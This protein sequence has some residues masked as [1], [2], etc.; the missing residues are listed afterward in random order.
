MKKNLHG[1]RFVGVAADGAVE[2]D[3]PLNRNR[4]AWWLTPPGVPAAGSRQLDICGLP[5]LAGSNHAIL[6]GTA[7]PTW[8]GTQN[9]IYS[10]LT[11][12]GANYSAV[13]NANLADNLGE[14]TVECWFQTSMTIGSGVSGVL[15]AKQTQTGTAAGWT[16]FLDGN[17]GTPGNVGIFISDT[18]WANFQ[19]WTTANAF[20][21]GK[22]HHAVCTL[23]GGAAGTITIYVDGVSQSLTSG[24]SGVL[25]NFSN[26]LTVTQG[27]DSGHSTSWSLTGQ[28][29]GA[30]VFSRALSAK[31]VLTAYSQGLQGYQT[32]DSPLRWISTRTWFVPVATGIAFD[33]ASNSGAL[34]TVVGTTITWNHTCTGTNRYLAVDVGILS[35]GASVVSVTYNGVNL[36]I[37]KAQTTVTALGDVECWGL[38]NPASGTNSIVVTI[39]GSGLVAG[40]QAVSYTNVDQTVPTEAAAGNQATNVGATDATVSVTTITDQ[41]WI[42]AA[43]IANDPTITAN[44]I[45]RSNVTDG[46][47]NSLADEDFGPQSPAAKTMGYTGVGAGVTWAIV[48]YGIRPASSFYLFAQS[49][50]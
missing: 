16:F 43:V 7:Q 3:H 15:V 25:A 22:W 29:A 47:T 39:S 9:N 8:S 20:N 10:P 46:L 24:G 23:T 35:A 34:A 19:L 26:A 18:G 30:S 4:L 41:D 36:T 32:T 33:A 28:I 6:T 42:H 11:F 1:N 12:N 2:W 21:D 45:S 14:F 37:I 5:A 48:G 40:G 38:A 17:G 27:W 44:Q 49:C 13:T 50:F 31:D